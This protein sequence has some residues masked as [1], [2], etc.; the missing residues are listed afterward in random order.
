MNKKK[1][2]KIGR[3]RAYES[4]A[5]G[6]SIF[7]LVGIFIFSNEGLQSLLWIS[8]LD[9]YNWIFVVNW[10]ATFLILAYFVGNYAG[11]E[12]LH[13]KSNPWLVGL[14]SGITILASG[15]LLGCFLGFM[16]NGIENLGT[17]ENPLMD[18]FLKPVFW[19]VVYGSLPAILMGLYYG[20]RINQS[21]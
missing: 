17:N 15:A 13:L 2:K 7:Y 21:K 12:I 11:K 4:V 1:A 3:L 18:Y 8:Y 20:W 14:K 10:I 5:I 6:V 9:L 19:I 16:L